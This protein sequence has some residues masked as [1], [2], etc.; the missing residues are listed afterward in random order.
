MKIK[1]A[2]F[3]ILAVFFVL[4]INSSTVAVNT[5]DIDAVLKKSVIDDQDK[6]VIDVFLSEAVTELVKTR[7]FTSIAK[8]RAVILSKKS[9]QS[10]CAQQFSESAYTHIQ[11]G[12]ELAQTLKTEERTTNVNI[13]LLI[14][15]DG[16]QD[17]RLTD[18]AMGM[19]KDEN[20]VIRYWAVHCLTNPAIVQQLNAGVTSNTEPATTIAEQLKEVVESSKPEIIVHIARFAA[21]INIPE[22][23]QL[24]LLVAD[25]RIKKYADWTVIHEFYDIIL[26][27]LLESKIPLSSQ[28]M[29]IPLPTTSLSKPAIARRFA[30]LYSYT[31]QRFIKGQGILN[32]TQKQHLASVLIE[33]EEKCVSRLLGGPQVTIRRAI[34]RENMAA[35][36]DEHNRLLGD[37]T[38][39]GQLPSKFGFDYSTTPNGP[40]RTA[41]IPL[42]EKPQKPVTE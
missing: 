6:K 26:L 31:I 42:P 4:A 38:S 29:G 41:P 37:E 11:A 21:N 8:V 12:F 36:S 22:G 30:Q 16:M 40:K 25:D 15:I 14:L 35:L 7:D 5:R 3:A 27:K 2:F 10:Q 23:E 1:Q 20:M 33:I 17:L 19:L 24:L 9:T 34:E 39:T 32:D 28:G 13:N 18:L